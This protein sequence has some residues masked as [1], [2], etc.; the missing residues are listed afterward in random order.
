[1]PSFVCDQFFNKRWI[2]MYTL[3]KCGLRSC[4]GLLIATGISSAAWSSSGVSK[5]RNCKTAVGTLCSSDA[6]ICKKYCELKNIEDCDCNTQS[7]LC[8]FQTGQ[9]AQNETDLQ[10]LNHARFSACIEE[11]G[12][13]GQWKR[14][15][16]VQWLLLTANKTEKLRPGELSVRDAVK[17]SESLVR[18]EC[19]NVH[20]PK[21]CEVR[22]ISDCEARAWCARII[23]EKGATADVDGSAVNVP[24]ELRAQVEAQ[25]MACIAAKRDPSARKTGRPEYACSTKTPIPWCAINSPTWRD[26][27]LWPESAAVIKARKDDYNKKL[28]Q[29]KDDGRDDKW[30]AKNIDF[31]KT[32][33]QLKEEELE[34]AICDGGGV[35]SCRGDASAT[36]VESEASVA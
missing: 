14:N 28:K 7:G 20:A 27:I 2:Y 35:K 11:A 23:P 33:G 30:I 8:A 3:L 12:S 25:L 5:I 26:K 24:T 32:R 16:T 9:N 13:Q 31:P 10:K 19:I 17:V 15:T 18:A 21:Y 36:Q 6:T 29:A 1:M 34:A 22:E 4:F